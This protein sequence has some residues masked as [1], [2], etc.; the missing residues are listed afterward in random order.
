MDPEEC[1]EFRRFI[2]DSSG[3]MRRIILIS[4]GVY[5]VITIPCAN[6]NRHSSK[7][8]SKAIGNLKKGHTWN[9][10]IGTITQ[11]SDPSK[12]ISL[13]MNHICDKCNRRFKT[14]QGYTRHRSNCKSINIIIQRDARRDAGE[15]NS[16]QSSQ[17]ITAQNVTI[18]NNTYNIQNNIVIR[19]IGKENPKWLTS[20]LLYQIM[21][22][23]PK[24]IPKLME[25]KHFNDA[26]PENKNIR[27]DTRRD[28]NRRLQVFEDGRWRIRD[29]KQTFYRV[30]VD[31]YDILCDALEG[32]GEGECEIESDK[33]F[34][35]TDPSLNLNGDDDERYTKEEILKLRKSQRFLNKLKNI[36]PIWEDF[37]DKTQ[38]DESCRN[39]LW[40][41]LK[42]LLLDRQMA[43]EQ[44][45]DE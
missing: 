22:D 34:T 38:Q 43:I 15:N 2:N 42:T 18:Q 36:Q 17:P 44:G 25:K 1:I 20:K 31:I 35:T 21:N 8:L 37:K 45:Y 13:D 30:L 6:W 32:D 23:I 29:S 26:F 14:N 33:S 40:E 5:Y 41:D 7:I 11:I 12:Y 28:I 24:A 27:V 4:P 39:E 9:L 3:N 19:D 16:A 10:E